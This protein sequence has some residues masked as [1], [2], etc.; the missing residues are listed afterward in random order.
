M[1]FREP[2]W[3][4]Y[5]SFLE[6]VRD[7]SLS[8]AARR[9][10]TTQPTIGRHIAALEA[11][12]QLSL[13]IRSPRGLLPTKAA[14]DLLPHAEAMAAAANAL[15]RA[16]SGDAGA[17]HGAV[18][19]TA[20][21]TIGCEVLPAI[22]AD[23]RRAHPAIVLELVLTNRNEDLLRGE[24]D[25]AVRMMR[26]TQ[27]AL[28]ARCIGPVAIGLYAH[29]AYIAAFGMPASLGDL[30]GHCLIGFDRDD[31]SFRAIGQG[32]GRF[33]RESFG[34]RCD[35]ELAQLAALRAGVGIGGCQTRLAARV[36]ALTR[37]LAED[38]DFKLEMWLAMHEDL[39]MTRRVR[40]VFD[41]LVDGL[42]HY[43]RG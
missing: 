40:L 12:L 30:S 22:L 15:A 14:L 31:H 3:E 17:D 8:G 25:I 16:A 28:V 23:F 32:A 13:F 26:P 38:V 6:V 21:E 2:G 36:P 1:A 5:R 43:V 7:G 10:A 33:S 29:E 11:R 34:F 20:S 27:Q 9:L 24:A 41:H 18:R 39:K 35:A 42:G 19:I 4:L 37:L